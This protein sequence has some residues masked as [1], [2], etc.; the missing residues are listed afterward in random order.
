ITVTFTVPA[1]IIDGPECTYDLP[2]VNDTWKQRINY[3]YIK[4]IRAEVYKL[5]EGQLKETG[6]VL[7]GGIDEMRAKVAQGNQTLWF[8]IAQRNSNGNDVEA[9]SS[10]HGRLRYTLE[11]AQHDTV[12]WNEGARTNKSAGMG[13]NGV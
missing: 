5:E 10:K 8:N 2:D 13:R 1:H 7:S 3:D 9:Q 6:A 11:E 4:I 12:Y